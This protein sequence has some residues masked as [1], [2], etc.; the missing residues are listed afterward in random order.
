MTEFFPFDFPPFVIPRR[1]LL[2]RFFAFLI[3]EIF[4]PT[5]DV[6]IPSRVIRPR[7]GSLK[8]RNFKFK[9]CA[10]MCESDL[11]MKDFKYASLKL[12]IFVYKRIEMS[13][14]RWLIIWWVIFNFFLNSKF[15][16]IGKENG[17]LSIFCISLSQWLINGKSM[18]I[19]MIK[20]I[21][22][23]NNIK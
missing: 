23:M 16:K 7:Y 12:F 3:I 14:L 6:R 8:S 11:K 20:I 10:R 5:P 19:I 2:H 18:H 15:W 9:F 4:R 1:F 17:R 21:Y 13:L 22:V